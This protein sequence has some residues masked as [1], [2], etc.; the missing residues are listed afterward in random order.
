M[1][2]YSFSAEEKGIGIEQVF[3]NFEYPWFFMKS[4]YI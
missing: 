4:P 1:L 3:D 2:Q